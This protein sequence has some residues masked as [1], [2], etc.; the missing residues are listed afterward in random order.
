MIAIVHLVWKNQRY[1][2]Q[3]KTT[4]L[5]MG[6]NLMFANFLWYVAGIY[7]WVA[8]VVQ[9]HS[10]LNFIPQQPSCN[11]V[12]RC[13]ARILIGAEGLLWTIHVHINIHA[14]HHVSNLYLWYGSTMTYLLLS[15][16][17]N[18]KNLVPKCLSLL[19]MQ[20]DHVHIHN[21]A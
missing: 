10:L 4:K 20:S 13:Q 9:L 21:A 1:I 19:Y 18:N 11:C 17:D 14:S 15:L 8:H 6:C 5:I 2:N 3:E 12:H 7:S 16:G